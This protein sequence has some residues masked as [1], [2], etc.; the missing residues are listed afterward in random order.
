MRLYH[1]DG[2]VYAVDADGNAHG[3]DLTAKD[4][5]TVLRELESVTVTVHD[6]VVELPEGAEPSTVDELTRKYALSEENPVLFG[7]GP[8][9]APEE[10]GKQGKKKGKR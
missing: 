5:V 9:Q 6:A 7:G 3:A 2:R 8:A 1:H 4:R 10:E